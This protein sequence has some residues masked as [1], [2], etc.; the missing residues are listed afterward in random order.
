M[1][2]SSIFGIACGFEH[3]LNNQRKD[4]NPLQ[5]FSGMVGYT[6]LGMITGLIYPISFPVLA[7][8]TLYQREKQE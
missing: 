6:S 2:I 3:G 8:Y 5:S 4:K 7:G 1:I